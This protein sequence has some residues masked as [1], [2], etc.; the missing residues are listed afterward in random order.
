M[1]CLSSSYHITLI[2]YCPGSKK[3]FPMCR[4]S[5]YSKRRWICQNIYRLF[6][7]IIIY[8]PNIVTSSEAEALVSKSV[9]L[10]TISGDSS[11]NSRHFRHMFSQLMIHDGRRTIDNGL[12]VVDYQQYVVHYV[13]WHILMVH[14]F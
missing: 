3:N 12:A 6:K 9:A 7:W 13:P 4:T 1:T 5:R 14:Y 11:I 8:G 2:F 10:E